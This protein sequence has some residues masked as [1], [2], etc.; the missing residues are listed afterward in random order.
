MPGLGSSRAFLRVHWAPALLRSFSLSITPSDQCLLGHGGNCLQATPSLSISLVHTLVPQSTWE[1]ARLL[2]FWGLFFPHRRLAS[3]TASTRLLALP[4]NCLPGAPAWLGTVRETGRALRAMLLLPLQAVV[5]SDQELQ[6]MDGKLLLSFSLDS[7][8]SSRRVGMG[9]RGL[10][11]LPGVTGGVGHGL[12][13]VV[14]EWLLCRRGL[15]PATANA[16]GHKRQELLGGS[17]PL[18][19]EQL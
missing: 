12:G 11:R 13:N 17:T 14:G 2:A 3:H 6:W 9:R 18:P 1:G 16:C 15:K 5:S 4:W 19:T 8:P 10:P 7:A